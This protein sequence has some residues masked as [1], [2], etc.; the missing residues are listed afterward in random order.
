MLFEISNQSNSKVL[1]ENAKVREKLYHL[2]FGCEE[3]LVTYFRGIAGWIVHYHFGQSKVRALPF[4]D[5][6]YLNI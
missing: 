1:Q 6:F 2:L 3:S 5:I 4:N